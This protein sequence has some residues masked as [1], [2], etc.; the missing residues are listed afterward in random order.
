MFLVG[1]RLLRPRM[2][3]PSD[4]LERPCTVG[5][6]G[7]VPPPPGPPSTSPLDPPLL[8]FQCLRLTAKT[9][10]WRQEDL[11]LPWD[12]RRRGVP[13]KPPPLPLQAPPLPLF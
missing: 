6:G 2:C 12:P 5:G 10:L 11:S 9:L 8:P 4:V 13:A 7:G 3:L 1:S